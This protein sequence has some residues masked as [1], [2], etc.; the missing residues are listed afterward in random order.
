MR[1]RPAL[2]LREPLGFPWALR[3]ALRIRANPVRATLLTSLSCTPRPRRTQ[4]KGLRVGWTGQSSGHSG[5]LRRKQNG[6]ETG[7]CLLP[8]NPVG[9]QAGLH[10]GPLCACPNPP[11]AAGPGF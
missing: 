2:S 11:P 9:S 3:V 4:R 8:Q 5:G 7:S 1:P 6:T 10:R